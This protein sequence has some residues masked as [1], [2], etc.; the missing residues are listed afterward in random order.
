MRAKNLFFNALAATAC[1]FTDKLAYAAEGI[2]D[3]VTGD[4]P[5]EVLEGYDFSVIS[6]YKPSDAA[7]VEVDGFMDGA[8]A[9]MDKKIELAEW[10]ERNIGWFRVDIEKHPELAMDEEGK[11]DQMV[12]APGMNRL[13][14]FNKISEDKEE[15]ELMLAMVIRE[16]TGDWVN[17][18]ECDAI[19][20]QSRWYYDEVVYFGPI[21][22]LK[23]GGEAESFSQA[24]MVDRYNF[25]EQRVGFFYNDDPE[26]RTKRDLEGDK[27]YIVFYNG[28]NSIPLVLE[29]GL[30]NIEVSRLIYE[31][32]IG[33]VKGTPRWGQRAQSAVF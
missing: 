18:I 16:L 7:S 21:E 19:Q 30:D 25:D 12:I 15:N 17:K 6:F 23:P 32:T 1:L 2:K 29:L 26:C 5:S 11:P 31:T 3:M 28:E 4:D 27:K 13:I 20:G 10:T 8:K 9:K 14:H 24:S 22:D 33:V